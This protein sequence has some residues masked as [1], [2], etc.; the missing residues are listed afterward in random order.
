M[1]V[2]LLSNRTNRVR[3]QFQRCTH[4]TLLPPL[5]YLSLVQLMKRSYIVLTDS[6]GIQEEAPG[7]GKPVLVLRE[8]TER[9]EAVDAG[10]VRL[11]GTNRERIVAEVERLLEDASAYR[12]MAQAINPYGD[13]CAAGR[14]VGALLGK[15]VEPFGLWMG[16][17]RPVRVGAT[18]Q[19]EMG[20]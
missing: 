6:G 15:D 17:E 12:R 8:V 19:V 14:I 20:G 10:T 1:E 5:D 11:V 7:L 13:G 2:Y 18:L 16:S 9:P 3:S 4:I